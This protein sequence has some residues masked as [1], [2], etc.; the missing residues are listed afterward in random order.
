[1]A[2]ESRLSLRIQTS[3]SL[4]SGPSFRAWPTRR[5]AA[6]PPSGLQRA[7][8]LMPRPAW[9]CLLPCPRPQVLLSAPGPARVGPPQAPPPGFRASRSVHSPPLGCLL[10]VWGGRP[11]LTCPRGAGGEGRV[12]E[13]E[14]RTHRAPRGLG[15]GGTAPVTTPRARVRLRLP[16][17]RNSRAARSLTRHVATGAT[18]LAAGL[19]FHPCGVTPVA[20]RR[21]TGGAGAVLW[22]AARTSMGAAEAGGEPSGSGRVSRQNQ[23]GWLM[24]WAE[25]WWAVASGPH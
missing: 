23:Q 20:A 7:E 10:P 15:Q 4:A 16:G 19:G 3:C 11:G 12:W 2:G 1:M 24:D 18:E 21:G 9:R 17:S 5:A 22:D 25:L 13:L 6:S 8:G 14:G